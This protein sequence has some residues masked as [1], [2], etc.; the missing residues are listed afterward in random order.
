MVAWLDQAQFFLADDA[1]RKR[2]R[3]EIATSLS[4]STDPESRAA[5]QRLLAELDRQA[6]KIATLATLADRRR[7]LVD[8]FLLVLESATAARP[9]EQV[10]AAINSSLADRVRRLE[11][12]TGAAATPVQAGDALRI[13]EELRLATDLQRSILPRATPSVDGLGVAF[14]SRPSSEVGGDFFDFYQLGPKRLLV[15]IG[16]ASGHG[17]DAAMVS[18]MAKSALY[19]HV[20]ASG[21]LDAS[22]CNMNR[23]MCDTLGDRRLMT[24]ALLDFDL[25]SGLLTWVN[26]GQAYP[27]RRRGRVV[28]ELDQSDYPLGGSTGG[29]VS[30]VE[31]SLEPGDLY[32]LHT[33]GFYEAVATTERSTAGSDSP[34]PVASSTATAPKTPL[35][36]SRRSSIATSGACPLRT[37]SPSWRSRCRTR[38]RAMARRESTKRR[39]RRRLRGARKHSKLRRSKGERLRGSRSSR[40]S[41]A[42]RASFYRPLATAS[43]LGQLEKKLGR[44]RRA[45]RAFVTLGLAVG[46]LLLGLNLLLLHRRARWSRASG[47]RC[48]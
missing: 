25:D 14:L 1:E 7:A 38:S 42:A 18:S 22:I 27:L 23:M 12:D 48:R 35:P 4:E 15:A 17:L 30:P 3:R 32:L 33:D 24:L 45:H 9:S 47:R 28:V 40:A 11:S 5:Q 13:R 6:D 41:R 43:Q 29:R 31:R 20:A 36:A 2:R 21:G 10:L 39:G 44:A 37:T 16:D 8:S 34:A 46:G 26:A 19:T